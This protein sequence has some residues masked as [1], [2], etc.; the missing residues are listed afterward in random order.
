MATTYYQ[1]MNT[2]IDR[3]FLLSLLK[4]YSYNVI[5]FSTNMKLQPVINMC[6]VINFQRTLAIVT[7]MFVSSLSNLPIFSCFSISPLQPL[8]IS[9]NPTPFLAEHWKF[10]GSNPLAISSFGW[11]F[12]CANTVNYSQRTTQWRLTTLGTSLDWQYHS[13]SIY[14]YIWI[15]VSISHF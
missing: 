13:L 10:W 15:Q 8:C 6:L 1:H 2:G 7:S 9:P 14:I 4:W 11:Y 12:F 3:R 5:T